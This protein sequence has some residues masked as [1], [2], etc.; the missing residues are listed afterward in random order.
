M[1]QRRELPRWLGVLAHRHVDLGRE[2][3]VVAPAAGE[4][5]ADDLLRLAARVD[6][7][8]VD[9]VDPGVERAVDDPDALVVVRLLPQS[10][11][12]MAPRHSLLT[13]DAG[14]PSSGRCSMSS[15]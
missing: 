8:G 2:D 1:I 11:N 15:P 7:S 4:R 12:I 13:E 14:A 9:E 10:P 5:L 3:D 6:V